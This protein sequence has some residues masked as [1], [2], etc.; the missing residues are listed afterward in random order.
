MSGANRL[1]K[2]LGRGDVGKALTVRAHKISGKA[3]E[4]RCTQENQSYWELG[5]WVLGD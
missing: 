4:N 1:I 2:V 3:A 5:N